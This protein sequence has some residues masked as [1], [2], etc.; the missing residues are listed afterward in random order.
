MPITQ[1]KTITTRPSFSAAQ[2]YANLFQQYVEGSQPGSLF[3]N[4]FQEQGCLLTRILCV[5]LQA[6]E[7]G[8][9]DNSFTS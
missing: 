1:G 3:V 2:V 6:G 9:S 8:S 5:L 7:Y 4:Q